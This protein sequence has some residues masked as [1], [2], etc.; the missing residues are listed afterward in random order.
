M[1]DEK[2]TPSILLVDDHPLT[3]EALEAIIRQQTD[4][5]IAGTAS[6]GEEAVQQAQKLKPD[7]LVTDV[8]MP[9][10]TGVEA[11]KK[12]KKE[13]PGLAV[14]MISNY[15][16]KMIVDAALK[17]GASGYISKQHAYEE[18]VPGIRAVYAGKRYF[19]KQFPVHSQ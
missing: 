14:L 5:I 9:G 15:T 1:S 11:V 17:A 18:L 8:S 3:C 2:K 10:M 7:V 4:W 12:I 19:C 16:N 13:Q 6:S